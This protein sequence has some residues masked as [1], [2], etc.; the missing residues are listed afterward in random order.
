MPSLVPSRA[1]ECEHLLSEPRAKR[2]RVEQEQ[3]AEHTFAQ[4]AVLHHSVVSTT[5]VTDIDAKRFSAPQ[6][7]RVWESNGR[8]SQGGS[9]VGVGPPILA[10]CSRF[11]F[12]SAA[13]TFSATA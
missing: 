2:S 3:H 9:S 5:S 10:T 8:K 1:E 13:D 12:P 7:S 6:A 4:V 11:P